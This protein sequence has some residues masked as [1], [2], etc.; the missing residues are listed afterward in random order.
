VITTT[1]VCSATKEN[2]Y[3]NG[4]PIEPAKVAFILIPEKASF[5]TPAPTTQG[6]SVP[7]D[8]FTGRIFDQE[9]L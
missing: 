4:R 5:T 6:A 9:G 2:N 1:T 3:F 8:A 7:A